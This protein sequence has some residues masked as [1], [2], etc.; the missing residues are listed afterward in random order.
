MPRLNVFSNSLLNATFTEGGLALNASKGNSILVYTAFWTFCCI[1]LHSF[2][3]TSNHKTTGAVR[4][5]G[6][7]PP[8]VP[9][10]MAFLAS[11]PFRMTWD[12][13][14]LLSSYPYVLTPFIYYA[15]KSNVIEASSRN[16]P[17][18]YV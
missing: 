18:L 7:V 8:P 9:L 17:I 16:W 6:G 13:V 10:S 14:H 1:A 15:Y 12:P 3:S 4:Q 11:L 5:R 2:W